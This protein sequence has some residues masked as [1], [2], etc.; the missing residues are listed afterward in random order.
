MTKG[1]KVKKFFEDNDLTDYLV[2][3][4]APPEEGGGFSLVMGEQEM[5]ISLLV[6][7]FRDYP[8]LLLQI[9]GTILIIKF[10]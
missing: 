3:S 8:Q 9:F 10:G 2:V 1:E 7:F 4:E 6:M 5:V